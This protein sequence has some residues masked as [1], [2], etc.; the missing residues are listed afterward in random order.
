M[1]EPLKVPNNFKRPD[2]LSKALLTNKKLYAALVAYKEVSVKKKKAD[3]ALWTLLNN[4]KTI[5]SLVKEVPEFIKHI[6]VESLEV[7]EG[8]Q[9]LIALKKGGFDNTIPKATPKKPAVK[10]KVV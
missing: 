4:H 8:V 7:S 6:P 9:T 10:R 5:A 1:Q 3:Y 2:V